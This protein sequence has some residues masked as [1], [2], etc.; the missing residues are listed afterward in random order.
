MPTRYAQPV[1]HVQYRNN[2][3]RKGTL[4]T[5]M[6]WDSEVVP[7]KV[8]LTLTPVD[9]PVSVA[10]FYVP[11]IKPLSLPDSWT[12]VGKNGKPLKGKMYDDPVKKKKKKKRKP[13]TMTDELELVNV[14]ADLEEAPSTSKAIQMCDRSRSTVLK[15]QA[16]GKEAKFWAQYRDGKEVERATRDSL[17]AI[18]SVAEHA[19]ARSDRGGDASRLA[20]RMEKMNEQMI[21]LAHETRAHQDKEKR[22]SRKGECLKEKTRRHAR[23]DAMAMRCGMLEQLVDDEA[24]GVVIFNP[25]AR[26]KKLAPHTT[27]VNDVFWSLADMIHV[28][29]GRAPPGASAKKKAMG[30]KDYKDKRKTPE[31]MGGSKAGAEASD[32]AQSAKKVCKQACE[33]M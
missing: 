2:I 3:R 14:L 5:E 21:N 6:I 24:V 19:K 28:E 25:T 17:H 31:M 30:K 22:K 33:M 13:K 29:V 10:D 23:S 20:R 4:E 26:Q 7:S 16:R 12:V 8:Q 15:E 1:R 27:D 9:S 18:F 32:P 11:E